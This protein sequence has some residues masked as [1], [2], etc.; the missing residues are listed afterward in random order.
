MGII[1]V[2][3]A[4]VPF[5]AGLTVV[6]RGLRDALNLHHHTVDPMHPNA[7]DVVTHVTGC[8]DPYV[9]PDFACPL[10]IWHNSPSVKETYSATHQWGPQ[11]HDLH[12]AFCT[13]AEFGLESSL[14]HGIA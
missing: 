7:A 11:D 8:G 1:K 10:P 13:I 9:F 14:G 2:H 6:R 5:S 3:Q 4:R 12:L